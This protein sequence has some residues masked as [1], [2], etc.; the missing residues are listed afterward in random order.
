MNQQPNWVEAWGMSHMRLSLMSFAPG[1]RTLR[2]VLNSAISGQRARIRLCNKYAGG[3]VTVGRASVALCDGDG[4]VV[5]GGSPARVTFRGREGLTLGPGE[6]AVSDDVAL[7]VPAG[8]D[9]C[10]S[11]YIEKGRLQ[12]GNC[13][14]NAR[15]LCARGDRCGDLAFRHEKRLRDSVISLAGKLLGMALHSPIPLFQA[16]ELLNG[17]GAS[18]IECFG[19]SLTQQGFWSNVFEEKIRRLY[20][21]RY[22]V[23]NKA[24]AGNRILRDTSPRFPL[25]GFFGVRALERVRDDILAYEGISHV[26]FC[27]GTNDYLQP[28]TIAGR[29][30]EWASAEEIAAGAMALVGMLRARKEIAV[31]GLN[32]VPVG[33]A[34]DATPEKNALRAR[35]NEWFE[36]CGAFD[37][38][39][40]VSTPFASPGN[41]DLPVASYVGKD[42][43]HPN[44]E[45]GRAIAHAIDYAVFGRNPLNSANQ[46]HQGGDYP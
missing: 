24:I 23:I 18:S 22:S 26:I 12:S 35:L 21:G 10:V 32:F 16:V 20:P 30:S 39:F 1:R 28:G 29:R 2:L 17:D 15:L 7:A 5:G 34:R 36:T 3:A 46:P 8:A 38:S 41:P 40:D 43:T 13:L 27:L 37:A 25:P 45:G 14:D 11:L 31:V 33:L 4:A 42:R 44:G 6:T 19:D 9:I